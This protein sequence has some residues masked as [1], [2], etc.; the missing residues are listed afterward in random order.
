MFGL[1]MVTW[2]VARHIVYMTVVYSLYA[3]SDTVSVPGCYRGKMGSIT[4]PFL[5]PDNF[6]H[7]LEPFTDPEG[8]VCWT[9]KV[10]WGFL[11]ALLFLQVLTLV[12]FSMI[13]KVAVKVLKG[14]QADDTRSDIEGEDELEKDKKLGTTGRLDEPEELQ[15]FEEEVGMESL[16]IKGRRSH[17]S[18]NRYRKRVSRASGISLPDRKELLGRIGCDK[19]IKD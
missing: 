8:L 13:V 12:W 10:K 11:I 4:G 17:E 15:P 18:P 14:G 7:L 2:V 6:G 16:N 1:F 19:E 3:Y 9:G 5:P